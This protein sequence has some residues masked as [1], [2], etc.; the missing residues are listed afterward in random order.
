MQSWSSSQ[1]VKGSNF[2]TKSIS[3]FF[4]NF[5]VPSVVVFS[6]STLVEID[7]EI[8]FLKEFFRKKPF[9]ITDCDKNVGI[10]IMSNAIYNRLILN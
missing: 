1:F 6:F 9:K 10:C 3:C 2:L 8:N 5:R 7:D 4:A